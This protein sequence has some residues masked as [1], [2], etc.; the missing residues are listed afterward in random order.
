MGQ[1]EGLTTPLLEVFSL[2]IETIYLFLPLK[3]IFRLTQYIQKTKLE[4]CDSFLLGWVIPFPELICSFFGA[5]ST[6]QQMLEI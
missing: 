3:A 4:T 2:P 5:T 1:V 6:E